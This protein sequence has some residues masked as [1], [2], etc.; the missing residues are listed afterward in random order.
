MEEK[1]TGSLNFGAGFSTIDNIVGF[2]EVTQG[3]FDFMNWPN[4]TGGGQKFRARVQYGAQRKD[5]ILALTEPYF[6]DR[7]LSLGGELFF[8]EANFLSSVYD[9]RNYGFSISA[10][11]PLG[12]FTGGECRV[13]SRRNRDLQRAARCL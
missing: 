10:R 5:I 1:R 13:S 11:R 6:L 12:R 4:F 7:R 2:V 9:Q 3:N 8:R